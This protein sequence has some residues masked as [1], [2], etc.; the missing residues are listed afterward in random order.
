VWLISL[1]WIDFIQLDNF[2]FFLFACFD[3]R[4]SG[5]YIV[6]AKINTKKTRVA[7]NFSRQKRGLNQMKVRIKYC[8]RKE[9]ARRVQSLLE[10]NQ[11]NK[12]R[13]FALVLKEC[14]LQTNKAH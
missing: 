5:T 3:F 9:E 1:N 6:D 10:S 7:N 8:F 4:P 11:V 13:L 2:Y 12:K 14:E